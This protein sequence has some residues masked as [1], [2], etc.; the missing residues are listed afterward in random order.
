MDITLISV[1]ERFKQ[2]NEYSESWS[3]LYNIKQIPEKPDLVKLC[4]DLQLKLTVDSKSDI[5]GCMLCDELVSLISLLPDQNVVTPI[6][7]LNFIKDCNLQEL[8]P[9]VWIALR[10]LLTIPVTVASGERSFSKLKLIKTYLRSTISQS[11]L[12]NLATLS[13]ENKIAENIDFDN[14]IKEFADRKAR[15]VKFY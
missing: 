9:N 6:F 11:R 1:N 5:D 10:I 2:L 12:T 8:Y 15:N 4:S 14:L 13:I 7:V 3:F